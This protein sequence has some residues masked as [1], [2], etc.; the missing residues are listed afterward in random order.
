MLHTPTG[1][2]PKFSYALSEMSNFYALEKPWT[3]GV[4]SRILRGTGTEPFKKPIK[5]ELSREKNDEWGPL[6]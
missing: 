1:G 6:S 2:K 4:P 5:P 3:F